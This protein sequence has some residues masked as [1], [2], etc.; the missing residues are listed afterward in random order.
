MKKKLNRYFREINGKLLVLPRKKR[1]AVMGDFR[2]SVS[3]FLQENPEAAFQE[4]EAAFGTPD[5]VAEGF[6]QSSDFRQ[7]ER[8][9]CLKRKIFA[10]VCIALGIL[11][12]A[13]LILG[14][15]YVVDIHHY[16]HGHF[17]D[18]PAMSGFAES[19]PNAIETY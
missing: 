6:L 9:L 18:S 3:A 17:E 10:A 5:Q 8:K 1:A 16:A 11:V 2:G 12:A 7:T 4:V 14:T 13:A 19:N 15:I